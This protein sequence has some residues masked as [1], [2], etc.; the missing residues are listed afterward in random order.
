VRA[1]QRLVV[2]VTVAGGLAFGS[3][4]SAGAQPQ[5]RLLY[6]RGAAYPTSL[7]SPELPLAETIKNLDRPRNDD[8]GLTLE[9]GG[10]GRREY[11]DARYQ[12]F[13][14]QAG[15]AT[16]AGTATL[17]IW[18]APAGLA[19][20]P[21][22][23]V[24]ALVADCNSFGF[25]CEELASGSAVVSWTDPIDFVP[26]TVSI[27][28]DPHTFPADRVL[29][30]RLTA[31]TSD[32]SALWVAY[33]ALE[34]PS[35]LTIE[36]YTT[37][38]TPVTTTTTTTKPPVTPPPTQAVTPPPT[39]AVTPP[40]T[41]AV[42]PTPTQAVT[43]TPTQAGP[44]E[45]TPNQT[46]PPLRPAAPIDALVFDLSY[47]AGTPQ[48]RVDALASAGSALGVAWSTL[49]ES[50]P[51][52]LALLGMLGGALWRQNRESEQP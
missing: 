28:L 20:G 5:E 11:D 47:G 2:S 33:D 49:A 51:W 15:E 37:A 8:P 10:V 52:L 40:P 3:F 31:E 29:K 38:M 13:L 45:T 19:A 7:L 22:A 46:T 44:G 30:L 12:D 16:V 26:A 14:S 50:W 25:G 39:Q 24:R 48:P 4:L 17:T 6:L 27:P 34:T 43:P 36:S 21:S 35:S 42:T 32:G 1:L 23:D 9:S 41:Q 18:V